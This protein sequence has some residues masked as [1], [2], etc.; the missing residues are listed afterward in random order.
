MEGI[1]LRITRAYSENTTTA[2]KQVK[3]YFQIMPIEEY[4]KD[5]VHEYVQK[6]VT[7]QHKRST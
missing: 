6:S 4:D 5:E 3:W 2:K 7:T 1:N